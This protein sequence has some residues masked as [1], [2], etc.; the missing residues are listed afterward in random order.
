[1][2]PISLL[3]WS[4]VYFNC[5]LS[6]ACLVSNW[7]LFKRG[8]MEVILLCRVQ[9]FM[10]T[11][12]CLT[13]PCSLFSGRQ[14]TLCTRGRPLTVFHG[15][16]MQIKPINGALV[17]AVCYM[18]WIQHDINNCIEDGCWCC[19]RLLLRPLRPFR[20]PNVDVVWLALLL[21]IWEVPGSCL[22]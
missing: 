12:P 4:N 13:W 7:L 16:H 20:R 9:I 22:C 2:L 21:R 10:T 1:M 18:H 17:T 14:H 11:S 19:K 5:L 6:F 3:K 8:T 15:V